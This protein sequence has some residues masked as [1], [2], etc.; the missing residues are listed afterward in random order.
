MSMQLKSGLWLQQT[1]KLMMTQELSQAIELLQYSTQ[2]LTE[3]LEE[4][5]MENPFIQLETPAMEYSDRWRRRKQTKMI[6]DDKNWIEQIA[7]HSYQLVDYLRL[8]LSGIK[9][10]KTIRKWI[11]FLLLNLDENGYLTIRPEEAAMMLKT[12]VDE[13]QT[14]VSIIQ[15]LEPAGVGAYHLQHCLLLQMEK[16]TNAPPLAKQIV[17]FHF[18]EFAEKKWKRLSKTLKV[19]ISDIQKASDYIQ[20]LNPRP[21]AAFQSSRTNEYITPDMSVSIRGEKIELQ[22]LDDRMPKMVFQ[23]EYFQEV[24]NHH[25]QELKMFLKEKFQDYQWLLKSLEQR[26]ETIQ[27]VGWKIV[28][29]QRDFFFEGPKKLT[30][31][32]MKEIAEELGIHESTVSRAVRG[33]YMQTPYGTLELRYFFTNAVPARDNA[34]AISSRRVKG[35]IE[36]MIAQEDKKHPLSDQEICDRLKM[37]GIMISRRTVAKYRDQLHIPS[38]S[39]RK[40][41]ES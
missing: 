2:E 22:F 24:S 8:Q 26:K 39:K 35:L 40:R 6:H 17:R 11:D 20:T 14:A 37:E 31:L 15:E 13:I 41:Y 5:T 23:K 4:K 30:S 3:Y 1:Q 18:H 29:K 21:G 34:E 7:D 19:E 10:P 27:K 32:T 9:V 16:D 28:E 36:N 25:D 33:K 38:S 12:S